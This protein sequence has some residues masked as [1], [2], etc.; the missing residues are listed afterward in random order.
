MPKAWESVPC[1]FCGSAREHELER[2]G[3]EHRYTYRRCLDCGLAYQSP[4]PVYDSE[5]IETAYEVYGSHNEAFWKEGKLTPFGEVVYQDYAHILKELERHLGRKGRL[6]EVGS[7]TGFFLKVA[8]DLGWTAIGVEISHSMAELA[9]RDFGVHAISADWV[10]VDFTEAFDVA[11]SSHVIEHVPDPAA[12]MKRFREVLRSD[13]ILCLS[14]PNMESLDRRFKRALKRL[15]LRKDRWEP[16]RTPDHL[17]EPCERSMKAFFARTGFE[18]QETYTY[19][20]E[21]TGRRTLFHRIYHDW[22]RW[23]AKQR[24]FLRPGKR[25]G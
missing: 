21:W 14:V 4:R 11:Y 20:S 15:G 6:L 8:Q 23:G 7:N 2:F 1:P 19:P 10:K 16:W 25:P 12:W 9:K 3:F 18:L 22:L 13:G 5:F 24:Y 17:Y